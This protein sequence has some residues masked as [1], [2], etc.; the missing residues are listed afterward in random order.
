[1]AS[2]IIE[3][4][5]AGTALD[6]NAIDDLSLKLPQLQALLCSISGAGFAN[7]ANHEEGMQK[8]L[9]ELAADLCD[10]VEQCRQRLVLRR[11]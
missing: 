5:A 4:D 6:I 3:Q 2:S 10:Q 9:L 11:S 1:M 8:R 7:F